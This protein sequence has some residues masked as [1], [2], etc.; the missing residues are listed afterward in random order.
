MDFSDI[1]DVLGSATDLLDTGG[2]FLKAVRE[3]KSQWQQLQSGGPPPGGGAQPNWGAS[4]PNWG[5]GA[6]SFQNAGPAVAAEVRQVAAANGNPWVPETTAGFG[7]I[8]LTG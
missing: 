5:G 2:K 3:I 7:G 8:D 1:G 4:Q 6:P